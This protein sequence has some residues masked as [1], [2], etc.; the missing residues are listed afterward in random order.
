MSP[1]EKAV[2][3]L[4]RSGASNEVVAEYLFGPQ[5][6]FAATPKDGW[7]FNGKRWC[8]VVRLSI[9]TINADGTITHEWYERVIDL[10]G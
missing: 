4:Y 5:W 1:A 6:S 2:Y 7:V 10:L 3:D 8:P 9:N